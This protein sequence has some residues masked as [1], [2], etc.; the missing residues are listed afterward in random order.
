[1]QV[2]LD[3]EVA[4][5]LQARATDSGRSLSGEANAWL[6]RALGL[7]PGAPSAAALAHQV[8]TSG[9]ASLSPARGTGPMTTARGG[10]QGPPRAR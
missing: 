7:A 6:R 5:A 3:D 4:R 10:W 1:M 2:R 8:P 9:Q